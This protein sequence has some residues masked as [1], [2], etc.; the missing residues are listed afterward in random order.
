MKTF[1]FEFVGESVFGVYQVN[2]FVF[3]FNK[4]KKECPRA[5]EDRWRFVCRK[6]LIM[7]EK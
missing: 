4:N 1:Q 5:D 6:R 3:L 7:F 2:W